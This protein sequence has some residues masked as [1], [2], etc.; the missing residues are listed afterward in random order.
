MAKAKH[1]GEKRRRPDDALLDSDGEEPVNCKWFCDLCFAKEKRPDVVIHYQDKIVVCWR[2]ENTWRGRLPE[3]FGVNG[4]PFSRE[5]LRTI[6]EIIARKRDYPSGAASAA[7]YKWSEACAAAFDI[8]I[9][10]Q[11]RDPEAAYV[12][13]EMPDILSRPRATWVSWRRRPKGRRD[14]RCGD[15]A[16][17]AWCRRVGAPEHLLGFDLVVTDIAPFRVTRRVA[18]DTY[19]VLEGPGLSEAPSPTEIYTNLQFPRC[20]FGK[21]AL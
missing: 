7:Y 13:P 17:A 16:V 15:H 20:K 12:A 2:C 1:V 19:E 8:F 3:Y 18:F 6:A 10:A 14:L 4:E 9:A 11:L 21:D 5:S